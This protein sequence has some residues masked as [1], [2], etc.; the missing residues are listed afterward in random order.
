MGKAWHTAHRWDLEWQDDVDILKLGH[1]V[2]VKV[3]YQDLETEHTD[4]LVK[5]PP[6]YVEPVH[7]HEASH[8]IAVLEGVQ[9]ANGEPMRAGD[10]VWASGPEPHGPFEY[11]EGCV[12]FVSFRGPSIK[13]VVAPA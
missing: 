7:T 13:H 10:Y 2:Q 11:P 6:G 3:L 5:F 8:S 4:M 1:G 9:I 12:V